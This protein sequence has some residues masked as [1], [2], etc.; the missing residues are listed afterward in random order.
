MNEVWNQEN[1]P[2]DWK[3]SHLTVLPK[4]GDLT[5]CE[6][7]RG[8]M[9]LDRDSLWKIMAHY[10]IPHKII[11]LVIAMYLNF[12]GSILHNGKLSS[13]FEILTGVR[14]GYL[15][16]PFLFLL[17]FDWIMKQSS[18]NRQNGIQWTLTKKLDD[19]DFADD[20]ALTST[21]KN[22]WQKRLNL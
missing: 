1:Y 5:K 4:K 10:G 2:T 8:I 7:Y 19:L 3:N 15:L 18:Q 16:S 9:F 14:Q 17:A 11:R 6:N 21:N 22:K 20:V 13:F 12:G